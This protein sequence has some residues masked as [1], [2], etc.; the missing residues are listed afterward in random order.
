M[1]QRQ[2]VPSPGEVPSQPLSMTADSGNLIYTLRVS[3]LLLESPCH[4]LDWAMGCEETCQ[5]QHC[6]HMRKAQRP[7]PK[8]A[9]ALGFSLQAAEDPSKGRR[10]HLSSSPGRAEGEHLLLD[11]SAPA[12]AGSCKTTMP[13]HTRGSWQ[14]PSTI[15]ASS[16]RGPREAALESVTPRWKKIHE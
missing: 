14:Q 13:V 3:S 5:I 4:Y 12:R 9:Q 8:A 16:S 10:A 15:D 11:F 7:Q 1:C 6:E 2:S